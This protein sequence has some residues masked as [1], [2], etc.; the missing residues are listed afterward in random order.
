MT[1][2]YRNVFLIQ[3]YAAASIIIGAAAGYSSPPARSARQAC[4][5]PPSAPPHSP[6]VTLNSGAAKAED[7]EADRRDVVEAGRRPHIARA[8]APRPAPE[9]AG[10]CTPVNPGGA[11]IR[12]TLVAVVPVILTPLPHIALHLMQPPVIRR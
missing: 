4:S 12:R 6:A 9:D 7:D 3:I 1:P 10:R 8:V 2:I 11:I 5:S